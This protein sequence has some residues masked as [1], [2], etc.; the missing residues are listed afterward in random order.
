MSYAT[1]ADLTRAGAP[2]VLPDGD[3]TLDYILGVAS[4]RVDELLIGAVYAVDSGGSPTDPAVTAT[5][6][7]AT[8]AQAVFQVE[9]A[10]SGQGMSG[11]D[12][13]KASMSIG[14]MS[15][16]RGGA[17]S[18]GGSGGSGGYGTRYAPDAVAILRTAGL[19]P[20]APIRW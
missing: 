4:Y 7:E 3:A 9:R 11:A 15:W 17:G 14:G 6:R 18:P 20:V 2:V 1:A 8:I 16:S 5:L 19:L 10:T 12:D 13:D